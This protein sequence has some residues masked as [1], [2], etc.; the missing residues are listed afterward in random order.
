MGLQKIVSS[1]PDPV[2]QALVSVCKIN[3][4]TS[5][6][7]IPDYVDMLGTARTLKEDARDLIEKRIGEI[8]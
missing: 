4:G 3:G 1:E 2:D 6:N 7:I 5:Q 8:C